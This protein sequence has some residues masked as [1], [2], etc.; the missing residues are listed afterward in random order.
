[1]RLEAA[2][3]L[4]SRGGIRLDCK[5]AASTSYDTKS[6]SACREKFSL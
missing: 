3:R 2:V 6:D 1:M 5:S 4:Y